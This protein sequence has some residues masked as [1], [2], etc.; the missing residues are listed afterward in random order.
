MNTLVIRFVVLEGKHWA[1]EGESGGSGRRQLALSRQDDSPRSGASIGNSRPHRIERV[2]SL[3]LV[4][5]I[6]VGCGIEPALIPFG[7]WLSLRLDP[8]GEQCIEPSTRK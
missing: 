1:S 6:T 3:L 4:V 8:S 5:I 7:D 2:Q